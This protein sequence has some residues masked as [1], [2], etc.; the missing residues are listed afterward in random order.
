MRLKNMTLAAAAVA[1]AAAPVAIQAQAADRAS[2][3]VEGAQ[4]LGGGSDGIYAIIAVAILGA[5]IALT[6]A[7]DDDE[8][9]SP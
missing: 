7:D 9:V 3:P 4:E 5:F 8:P 2:A 6:A 1:F